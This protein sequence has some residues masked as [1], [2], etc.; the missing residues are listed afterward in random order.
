MKYKKGK[1]LNDDKKENEIFILTKEN[2]NLKTEIIKLNKEL[3]QYKIKINKQLSNK[4]INI[5]IFESPDKITKFNLRRNNQ[6][7]QNQ[8][9]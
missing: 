1:F 2:S 9:I 5:R 8:I 7:H 6:S 3:K 4:N